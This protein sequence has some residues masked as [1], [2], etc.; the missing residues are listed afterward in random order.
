MSAVKHLTDDKDRRENLDHLCFFR[1]QKLEIEKNGRDFT[2][3]KIFGEQTRV[4]NR[5]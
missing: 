4:L 3:N 1:M 2:N 5:I